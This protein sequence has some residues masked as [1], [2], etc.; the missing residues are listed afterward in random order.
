MSDIALPRF[1]EVVSYHTG[2][3]IDFVEVQTDSS[4]E[5]ELDHRRRGPDAIEF[6]GEITQEQYD[7]RE[8]WP[9]DANGWLK[10][11]SP[12]ELRFYIKP[13]LIPYVP[14]A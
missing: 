9:K 5:V 12:P 14:R 1:F 11:I 6:F 4:V 3:V 13:L 8:N 2:D 10:P 7:F